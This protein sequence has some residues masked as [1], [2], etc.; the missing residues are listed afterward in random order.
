MPDGPML[1]LEETGGVINVHAK[2]VA[3]Q[4]GQE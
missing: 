3:Q 2:G 1:L 4:W